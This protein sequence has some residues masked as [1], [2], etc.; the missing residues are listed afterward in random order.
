[1]SIDK[2][3]GAANAPS[4]LNCGHHTADKQRAG[5]AD[6]ISTLGHNMRIVEMRDNLMMHHRMLRH[7]AYKL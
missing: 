3:A 1:V 2:R 6:N 5:Q 7:L 4:N